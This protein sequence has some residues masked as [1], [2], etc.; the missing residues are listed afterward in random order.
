MRSDAIARSLTLPAGILTGGYIALADETGGDQ[1]VFGRP[2]F[3]ESKAV[4]LVRVGKWRKGG[5]L[6]G[7][8]CYLRY[9]GICI[10]FDV[11][12]LFAFR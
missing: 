11:W 8:V 10:S 4:S 9:S 2:L 7:A 12:V 6:I 3:F 5:G 1:F